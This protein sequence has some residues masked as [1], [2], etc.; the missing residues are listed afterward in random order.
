MVEENKAET[1]DTRELVKLLYK[2]EDGNPF[3]LTDSQV[4]IFDAIFKRKIQ[5]YILKLIRDLESQKQ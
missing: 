5:E 3:I 2:T 1:S 4:K